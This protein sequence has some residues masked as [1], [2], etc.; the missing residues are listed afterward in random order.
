M[1]FTSHDMRLLQSAQAELRSLYATAEGRALTNA[2]ARSE[3]A[4]AERIQNLQNRIAADGAAAE[5]RAASGIPELNYRGGSNELRALITGQTDEAVIEHRDMAKGTANAGAEYVQTSVNPNVYTVVE[6]SAALFRVGGK[7]P[8]GQD[9]SPIV[10]PIVTGA[11]VAD[12]EK[13]EGGTITADDVDTSGVTFNAYRYT[14]LVKVN[15]TLRSSS[16]VSVES[17][18]R[19]GL[20]VRL[21]KGFGARLATGTGSGQPQGITV[22]AGAGITAG[23]ATAITT[24]ELLG[25]FHSIS[26]D[27]RSLYQTAWC[28]SDATWLAIGKLKDTTN[29]YLVGDM[30][31]GA[32]PLLLGRPVILDNNMPAMATGNR[33]IVFGAIADAFVIRHTD[34]R[35]NMD[36]SRY[37]EN[38]QT[39][40]RAVVALDSKVVDSTAIKRITMA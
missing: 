24:D 31:Q 34:I 3:A 40:F 6:N 2:E 21:A 10:L 4:I 17:I 23:L 37:F 27:I 14:G 36:E 38:D 1:T 9:E 25:L 8:T 16:V 33:P 39:A 18:V 15:N 35:V 19:N 20:G 32:P 5:A 12:Q 22:G 13:A 29:N 11:G 28:M 30:T 7:L 26:S